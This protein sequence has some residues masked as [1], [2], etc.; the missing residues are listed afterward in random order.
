[1]GSLLAT[2]FIIYFSFVI[3]KVPE[4]ITV[5]L[6]DLISIFKMYRRTLVLTFELVLEVF[7][8]STR[9]FAR[10]AITDR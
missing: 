9:F 7:G 5:I 4:T 8:R 6:S 1:M 10:F 3:K 2:T